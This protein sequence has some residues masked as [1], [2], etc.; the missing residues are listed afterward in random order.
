MAV[1][2]FLVKWA[3]IYWYRLL[4]QVCLRMP[5]DPRLWVFGARDRVHYDENTKYLFE[6]VSGHAPGIRAVWVTRDRRIRDRLREKGLDACLAHSLRGYWVGLRAGAALI[7][8]SYRDVNWFLLFGCPVVQL[9]HGTPMM[10]NDIAY[11]YEKYAFVAVAAA[12]FLGEQRLGSGD[13]D[14]RLTGYPRSDCLF[15]AQEAQAVRRL[16][17]RFGFSKLVFYVP[18]HRRLPGWD[19]RTPESPSFE[20][21]DDNGFDVEALDALMRKHDALFV[22]K[23]H[24]L[25][26]APPRARLK[27]ALGG[28]R[29]CFVDNDDP[30]ADAFEYLRSA[31]VLI[32]DYSS[33]LF[34]FLL[35]GRPVL[36]TPFDM[37]KILETRRFRFDY[38]QITP[39]PKARDWPHLLAEL[40]R[41]L[42]GED[43]WAGARDRVA[44]RFNR[45]RDGQSCARVAAELGGRLGVEP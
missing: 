13:F 38:D 19:G 44:R 7:N 21:F 18:T 45:F 11:L 29:F 36:F 5:R 41:I 1:W 42:A 8:V 34:D 30:M 39:G 33:I 9:W 40:D 31:D 17:E 2:A 20:L 3:K 24:P 25:Q 14:F 32:T 4:K 6:Y 35:T 15:Q 10:Y 26:P 23:L 43:A 28:S 16:R 22:M 27:A 12:E 37:D